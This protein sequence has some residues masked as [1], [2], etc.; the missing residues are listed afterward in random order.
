MGVSLLIRRKIKGVVLSV[1]VFV[2]IYVI[3]AYIT[4][5]MLGFS[6]I[7]DKDGAYGQEH[8]IPPPSF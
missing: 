2:V 3:Y 6:D 8:H 1:Y 7:R 5:I 4:F